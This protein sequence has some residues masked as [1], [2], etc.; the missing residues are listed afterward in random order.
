VFLRTE[1]NV[2]NLR[3]RPL[4]GGASHQLTRFDTDLIFSF[5]YSPDGALLATARGR[6]S[7][8][9]VLIRNFR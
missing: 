5:A 4:D 3:A 8:D 6:T 2:S 1:A 9:I 7:G